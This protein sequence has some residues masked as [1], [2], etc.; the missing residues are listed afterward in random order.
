MGKIYFVKTCS[1]LIAF[2]VGHGIVMPAFA[3]KIFFRNHPLIGEIMNKYVLM[4]AAG[5]LIAAAPAYYAFQAQAEES[6]L[7]AGMPDAA[8]TLNQ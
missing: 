6:A 3:H 8:S 2:G 4:L 1:G 5:C 7:S